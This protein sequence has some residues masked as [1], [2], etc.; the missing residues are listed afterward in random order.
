MFK[1]MVLKGVLNEVRGL[2]NATKKRS[3]EWLLLILKRVLN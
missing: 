3:A 2:Q 1:R